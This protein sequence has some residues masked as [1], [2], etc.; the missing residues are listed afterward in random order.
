MNEKRKLKLVPILYLLVLFATIQQGFSA[1]SPHHNSKK[2]KKS[3]TTN[4]FGSSV[5]FPV[6]GNVYPKGYV[7]LDF[8]FI[9]KKLLRNV[10]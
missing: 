3:E 5:I 10:D 7:L 2:Q 9:K 1:F 4:Q 8:V 6:T